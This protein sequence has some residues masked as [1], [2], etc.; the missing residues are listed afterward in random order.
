MEFPPADFKLSALAQFLDFGRNRDGSQ[1]PVFLQQNV[2]YARLKEA[3]SGRFR[4]EVIRKR[5]SL[6][7]SKVQQFQDTYSK[8]EGRR[9]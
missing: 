5:V 8:S 4:G 3:D 1:K 7:L 9:L 6:A 2:V